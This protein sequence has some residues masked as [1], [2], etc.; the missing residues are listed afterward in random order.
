MCFRRIGLVL[1]RKWLHFTDFFFSQF[2]TSNS[3][4][5]APFRKISSSNS[6]K[7]QRMKL[8]PCFVRIK[9]RDSA[10]PEQ[11]RPRCSARSS[12]SKSREMRRAFLRYHVYVPRNR[13]AR[14]SRPSRYASETY[15]TKTRQKNRN[16]FRRPRN[17]LATPSTPG[18]KAEESARQD[19][20]RGNP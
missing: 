4:R 16:F 8:M 19:Y 20:G 7:I 9:L 3:Y 6:M 2:P 13:R 15:D 17:A 14:A 1:L 12:R 11:N 10:P 5:R 18:T